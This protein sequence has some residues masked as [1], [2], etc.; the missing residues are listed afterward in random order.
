MFIICELIAGT[1]K[2]ENHKVCFYVIVYVPC[3]IGAEVLVIFVNELPIHSLF[4][5]L[6][7]SPSFISLLI[8]L[9]LLSY[10]RMNLFVV[11]VVC[12]LL[13]K[14]C[15]TVFYLFILFYFQLF[16]IFV[17]WSR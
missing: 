5:S 10:A 12:P 9:T 1:Q 8:H 16:L 6:C 13:I 2:S 15:L 14:V 17:V 11:A 7:V 3:L 4:R